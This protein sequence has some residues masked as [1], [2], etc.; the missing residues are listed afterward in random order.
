MIIAPPIGP[1]L[2]DCMTQDTNQRTLLF[3]EAEWQAAMPTVVADMT[4]FLAARRAP[5]FK[6]HVDHGEGW[7][8]GSFLELGGKV[9]ILTNE[10]VADA[11]TPSQQLASQLHNQED[12]WRIVGNHVQL[13]LPL[14]LALL[15]VPDVMWATTHGSK[16]IGVEQIAIAHDPVEGELL[17]F[18]GFAGE[19][20]RFHF[21]T[22]FS[23]PTC[24]TA[25]ETALPAD[26][27]F[28]GRFH[29]GIDYR[30]DLAE[31]VIGTKGL[32][33]PP[34]LSG[35][36]VWNTRFVAAK[37]AGQNWT[38]DIAQVT[39]VVWGWPSDHGCIVATRAEYVRSF[40][41]EAA[42]QLETGV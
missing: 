17:A 32:P 37:M 21:G 29:F 15:P 11:R 18:S 34:G 23:E 24:S 6:D 2:D 28:S 40:L 25:R 3:T 35:S 30:P 8:S 26:D 42:R 14:D 4:D 39:G 27:R 13:P 38:P 20:V 31:D 9:F 36:T 10:H 19:R 7:G 1:V 12:I 33:L 5:V 41:L 16:A 22:L